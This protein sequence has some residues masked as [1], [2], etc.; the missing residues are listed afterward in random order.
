MN[1]KIYICH[2][3]PLTERKKYLDDVI[4]K[5]GIPF[6]FYSNFN[7]ENIK[8]YDNK[9][10]SS[11]DILKHK[12][13]SGSSLIMS[14]S[15]KATTLEHAK[16][17]EEIIKN[18]YDYSII[19]EDDAILIDD[20]KEQLIKMVNNLPEDWDVVYFSSGCGG[21]PILRDRNGTNLV[22]MQ[23]RTSWTANGYLI[24]NQTAKKFINFIYPIALP[25]DFELS[26][27][28][29]HLQMNVY[30]AV[31]PLVYEGSNP[32]AGSRYR[33]GSSQIR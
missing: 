16:I 24:N 5:L 12:G 28:Q 4:P 1:A 29:K 6:D 11:Q 18:N 20:F 32:A 33:Y 30:W 14:S 13:W 23:E 17:Y 27:I 26:F 2:Y 21:R 8:N 19:L 9:F 25:I 10:S 31:N 15:I 3:P 7:R 22:K